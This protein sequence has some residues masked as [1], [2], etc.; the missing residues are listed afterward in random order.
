MLAAH[1][2]RMKEIKYYLEP[3]FNAKYRLCFLSQ[4]EVSLMASLKEEL[5]K[6]ANK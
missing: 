1:D 5:K 2:N 6:T 3:L 4:T